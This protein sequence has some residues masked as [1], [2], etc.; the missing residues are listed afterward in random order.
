M[1]SRPQLVSGDLDRRLE[2]SSIVTD[3]LYAFLALMI[4]VYDRDW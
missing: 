1:G 2:T 3:E 4:E